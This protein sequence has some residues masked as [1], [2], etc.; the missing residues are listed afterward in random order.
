LRLDCRVFHPQDD[1]HHQCGRGAASVVA[2]DHQER[3]SFPN[4]DAALK[5]LYL[6]I[7]NAGMRWRRSTE[8]T[9]AMG[10]FAIQ[11][12]ARFPGSAR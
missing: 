10:Q 5:L 9:G 12:G 7:R 6:A 1:L 2:Q 4:D 3:G 8:W 11:F